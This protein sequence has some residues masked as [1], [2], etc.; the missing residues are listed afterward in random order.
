MAELNMSYKTTLDMELCA[1]A[2]CT[3]A[4]E[5]DFNL[6]TYCIVSNLVTVSTVHFKVHLV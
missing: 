6:Y 4:I 1:Q 2:R 3:V 5:F